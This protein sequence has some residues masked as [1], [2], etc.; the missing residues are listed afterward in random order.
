MQF[1]KLIIEKVEHE[2]WNGKRALG[3]LIEINEIQC[4]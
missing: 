2:S 1:T 3:D 4:L